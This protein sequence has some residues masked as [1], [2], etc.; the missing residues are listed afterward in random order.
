M[1]DLT[2]LK[3][4]TFVVIGRA[5][6]DFYTDPGIH[7][8]QADRFFACLGGSAANIAVA[9]VKLGAKASLVTCVSDDAVGRFVLNELDKYNVNRDHVRVVG[10][11]A[12]TSL[13][14]IES[15]TENHQS[16]IY[17]NRVAD[18][19]MS[20]QDTEQVDYTAFG[21]CITTGT[22]FASEPSNS[23]GRC[24]LALAKAAGLLCIFDVD[25]RPY[26]W[27]SAQDAQNAY[28]DIANECD[29]VVG[30]DDE[31]GV[32]AGDYN[33]GLAY[34]RAMAAAGD[35]IVVYKKGEKGAITFVGEQE[36][37]TGI[38]RVE[39]LK[40]TGAGDSFMGGFIAGLSADL[41]VQQAVLQGSAAAALVV[42]K[43]GCAPA[44]PTPNELRALMA[45]NSPEMNP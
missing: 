39:A 9:L 43:M 29:I 23:A 3:C 7:T 31:F 22:V 41:P 25:H 28:R 21:A 16:V 14:V 26:S 15:R 27:L 34:A 37:K 2:H 11:E 44:M 35:K 40:P 13:A 10:G 17:R 38:Y 30:N 5:G 12:R 18:F 1:L 42:S 8:E 32:M 45:K 24:G 19:D 20:V 33:N 4:N 36:I 6:I